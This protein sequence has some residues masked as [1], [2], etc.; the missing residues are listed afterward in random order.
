M[1]K[2]IAVNGKGGVGKTSLSALIVRTLIKNPNNRVLAIDG[3]PAVG[4][5]TALG[6]EVTKTLDDIR[7]SLVENVK[8]GEKNTKSSLMH[9]VNYEMLD[10]LVENKGFAFL[11]IG[12]PEG[13]GCYCKINEYL[14]NIIAELAPNFDY[15]IIDGEAGIEQINRRVME[16]VTHLL[17]ISDASKK[18]INVAKTVHSLAKKA[19]TFEKAGLILNRLKSKTEVNEADLA[20]L[21]CIGCLLENDELRRSDIDGKSI[22]DLPDNEMVTYFEKAIMEFLD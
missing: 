11:A 7:N 10:A 3:D 13:K 20:P 17:M 12:R 9:Q 16:K 18:G 2:I 4:F 1:T 21:D 6:V 14:K 8:E 19:M 5:S 15:I 22:L